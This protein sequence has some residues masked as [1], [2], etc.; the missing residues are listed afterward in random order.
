MRQKNKFP[1][2]PQFPKVKKSYISP[3]KS[4]FASLFHTLYTVPSHCHRHT[5]LHPT[6]SSIPSHP[7][8]DFTDNEKEE[9]MHLTTLTIA[10]LLA[11][12]ISAQPHNYEA[13]P[14][15]HTTTANGTLPS[16]PTRYP[17]EPR[18]THPPVCPSA[19]YCAS[20]PK[21]VPDSLNPEMQL[22]PTTLETVYRTLAAAKPE[23]MTT[24]TVDLVMATHTPEV[25]LV[26]L[27]ADPPV[28]EE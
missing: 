7:N 17:I 19:D 5:R 14:L 13:P 28:E 20:F 6:A 15:V 4:N 25:V 24:M 11:G 21:G 8:I 26:E 10:A 3:V 1:R 27:H 9:M 18:A 12:L 23:E 16:L 22:K 2:Q